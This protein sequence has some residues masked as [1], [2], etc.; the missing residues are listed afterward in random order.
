MEWSW[1]R[2]RAL[3]QTTDREPRTWAAE[4]EVEV[5]GAEGDM[6]EAES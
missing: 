1:G 6:E 4:E 3:Q 5:D 2:K